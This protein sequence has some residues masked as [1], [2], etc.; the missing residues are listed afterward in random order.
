M[1]AFSVSMANGLNE[2]K[3]S[4]G[5]MSLIAGIFG[6]FQMAM[7]LIGWLCIHTIIETFQFVRQFIPWIA[8]VLL[9]IL[10]TKMIVEG[11]AHKDDDEKPA[12]GFAALFV[13]GMQLQ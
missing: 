1:D 5:R 9:L 11:I 3:M 10:G 6:V 4:F 12:V 7:P 8:L 13:Q 2:P